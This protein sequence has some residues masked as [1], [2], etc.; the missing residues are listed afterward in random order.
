MYRDGACYVYLA[1]C[2]D[3]TLYCGVS[4][5]P[6]WRCQLHSANKGAKYTKGRG[7]VTLVWQEEHPTRGDAL[8][9]EAAIK[10]LS[11]SEKERLASSGTIAAK[12][13]PGRVVR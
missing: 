3:G 10:R 8:R 4:I 7:P 13:V 11:K 12:G 9:R 2:T 5:N 6:T 1:R